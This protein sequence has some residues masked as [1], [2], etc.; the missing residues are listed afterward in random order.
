M[1]VVLFARLQ[2]F[3]QIVCLSGVNVP[4]AQDK[5]GWRLILREEERSSAAAQR[6][7]RAT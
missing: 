6:A 5:R 2:E 7:W 1:P 4:H 3:A